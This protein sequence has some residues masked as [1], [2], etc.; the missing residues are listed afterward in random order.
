MAS[1][2]IKAIVMHTLIAATNTR[3]ECGPGGQRAARQPRPT[4]IFAIASF[5]RSSRVFTYPSVVWMS[6]DGIP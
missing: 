4:T 6:A 2:R 5:N 1:K 3:T